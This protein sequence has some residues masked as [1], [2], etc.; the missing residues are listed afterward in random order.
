MADYPY[1]PL[2]RLIPVR[3][4]IAGK[5]RTFRGDFLLDTGASMTILAVERA[6][7]MGYSA[8]YTTLSF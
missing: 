6:D 1:I 2:D 7:W 8:H 4:M 3:V 5:E